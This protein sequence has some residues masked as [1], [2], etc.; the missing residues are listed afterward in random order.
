MHAE[1][2]N[3]Q[4]LIPVACVIDIY[5]YNRINV[6]MFINTMYK[7]A[8]THNTCYIHKFPFQSLQLH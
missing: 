6:Q 2:A 5:L 4:F 3:I 8:Y 7:H 1:T